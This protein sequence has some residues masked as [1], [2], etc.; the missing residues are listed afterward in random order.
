ME[1][2]PIHVPDEVLDDLRARLRRTRWPDQIPGIGWEQGTELGWLQR[3]V[4]T[5]ADEFDWRAWERRLNALGHFTSDG[6]HF[7]H[8]RAASSRG[9]PL[10]L[11]HGWPGSFLDYV[12]V[13]PRTASL[14]VD[15]TALRERGLTDATWDRE[16]AGIRLRRERL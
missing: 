7:V 16:E 11:T 6:I 15:K 3:L 12:D 9:V 14:R 8:Q 5:W 2:F 13:L 4:S 10:I 1:P